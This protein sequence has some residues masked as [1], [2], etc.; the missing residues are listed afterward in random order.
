[1]LVILSSGLISSART[2]NENDKRGKLKE[3]LIYSAA[4]VHST[5]VRRDAKEDARV[6]PLCTSS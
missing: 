4:S 1:V 3:S 2:E 5:Q 6:P